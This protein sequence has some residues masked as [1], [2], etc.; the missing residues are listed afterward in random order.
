MQKSPTAIFLKSFGYTLDHVLVNARDACRITDVSPVPVAECRSDHRMV[1][2]T[3]NPV[4]GRGGQ[5]RR[6]LRASRRSEK[7]RRY[8]VARLAL[9][10]TCES[11]A[12]AVTAALP[13]ATDAEA[14][15]DTTKRELAAALRSAADQVLGPAHSTRRR[16]GWQA[17]HASELREM[18]AARRELAERDGLGK[19]ERRTAR[20]ALRAQ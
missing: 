8:G 10:D 5:R 14:S 4:R 12:S 15:L 2:F 18:A 1:R 20:R 17:A 19:D 16:M 6:G 13:C 9:D 7:V 3:V 11:F